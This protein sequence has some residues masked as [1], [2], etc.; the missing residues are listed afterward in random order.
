MSNFHTQSPAGTPLST[1]APSLPEVP[2]FLSLDRIRHELVLM[3][4]TIV[5]ALVERAGFA[6][7]LCIYEEGHPN[8][9]FP[10]AEKTSF[11]DYFFS[12]MEAVHAKVRRYTSPDE[13]PFTDPSKLPQP[14]LPP[15]KFPQLLYPNKININ[16]DI[17]KMYIEK[18]IPSLCKLGDDQNYGSS[19]TKDI[20]ALQ[21]LS[22]R[23]HFG[24]F[25]AEAKFQDPALQPTYIRLIRARDAAGIEALLT[26]RAV[27]ERLLKRI[28]LK[29]FIFGQEVDEGKGGG[30]ALLDPMEEASWRPPVTPV[31]G[32]PAKRSRKIEPELVVNLYEQYVIPLTKL[33]EVEY[34]LGRLEHADFTPSMV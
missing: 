25:V 22:R 34:L 31:A 3:E 9:Q 6:Q 26:N 14:V 29:A 15:M 18:I 32:K 1:S 2:N 19:S 11:L 12:E 21:V 33:V 30:G 23:I 16:T 13:Y 7:N 4:D 24:K 28:R 27:E 10:H 5:F 17:K 8:F 20:E